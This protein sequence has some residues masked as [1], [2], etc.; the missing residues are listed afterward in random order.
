M[1]E[2]S[3]PLA[4][5]GLRYTGYVLTVLSALFLLFSASGKFLKPEGIEANVA[6]LGWRVDQLTSL[7]IVEVACVLLYV[8]PRTAVF[9][10]VLTTAYLGGAVATHARIGDPYFFPIIV[11]I[12]VWLGIYLREPRLWQLAPFRR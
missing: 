9:G 7:G 11:G 3:T 10:A 8:I 5:K 2:E 1:S 12:V 4:P 6:P